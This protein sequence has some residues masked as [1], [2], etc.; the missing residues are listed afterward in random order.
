MPSDQF[1]ELLRYNI[2]C[3]YYSEVQLFE[4]WPL[5]RPIKELRPITRNYGQLRESGGPCQLHFLQLH[6]VHNMKLTQSTINQAVVLPLRALYNFTLLVTRQR[7]WENGLLIRP[8]KRPIKRL[9]ITLQP[10]PRIFATCPTCS[11]CLVF[12]TN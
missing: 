5:L 10:I 7:F 8:V 6:I 9:I 11:R 2:A 3:F 4:K 12:T 1:K